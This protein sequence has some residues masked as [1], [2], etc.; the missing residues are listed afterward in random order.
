M[1][2]DAFKGHGALAMPGSTNPETYIH[3]REEQNEL[4][5]SPGDKL[6]MKYLTSHKRNVYAD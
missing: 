4:N 5:L 6:H 1:I 3:I 2:R